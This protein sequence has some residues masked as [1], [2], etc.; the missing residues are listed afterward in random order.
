[1]TELKSVDMSADIEVTGG[2][3]DPRDAI[4]FLL[5]ILAAA[6]VCCLPAIVIAAWSALL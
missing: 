5:W 3:L 4:A 6:L 2:S 1:M